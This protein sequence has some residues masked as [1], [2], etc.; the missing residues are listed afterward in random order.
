MLLRYRAP[1]VVAI[2][3]TTACA[4]SSAPRVRGDPDALLAEAQRELALRGVDGVLG[5][6]TATVA[7]DG[8]S[9]GVART[10]LHDGCAHRVSLEWHED[11]PRTWSYAVRCHDTP[12]PRQPPR[13]TVAEIRRRV[14]E[15]ER[16]AAR[17]ARVALMPDRVWIVKVPVDRE[18][19][20]VELPDDCPAHAESPPSRRRGPRPAPDLPTPDD[21]FDRRL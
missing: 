1:V 17:P 19:K 14:S 21:V 6:L 20:T 11:R 8:K 2:L 5:E 3:L 15:D 9:S 16:D 7:P 12:P 4:H 13:C 18:V 10:T